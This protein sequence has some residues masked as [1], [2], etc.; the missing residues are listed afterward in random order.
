MRVGILAMLVMFAAGCGGGVTTGAMPAPSPDGPAEDGAPG[1]GTGGAILDPAETGPWAVGVRT[2]EMTDPSRSRT[3]LVDV[4]YPVDPRSPDGSPNEYVLDGPFGPLYQAQ[5]PARRGATPAEGPWPLVLFS[6][7]YGGVRF[8]SHFLTEHLASHGYVVAGPDHPG[9]TLTDFGQLGDDAATAQSA[10]DRP[11]DLR[12]VLDRLVLGI[13]SFEVE[14]DG[15]RVATSGH[16]FGGWTA[17]ETARQDP[18]IDVIVPMA[19]GFKA[20]ATPAFVADLARPLAIVGGGADHTCP[21]D[22]DQQAPYELAQPA[23]A[24]LKVVDAGHLDF[25]NLCDVPLAAIFVS[26]GCDPSSVDP[27]IVRDRSRT[28]AAAFL[29]RYLDVD[30]AYDEY[31]APAYVQSLGN[32]QFW[33]EP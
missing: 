27:A 17:L 11:L 20:G 2:V 14:V 23:K 28:I 29:H 22:T 25:S 8:Q 31:L 21:F 9:N 3:F 16:S 15:D 7:G 12:F 33:R 30:A 5:T 6:H 24:L 4:W 32:V 18:R 1:D 26:D 19:P 13:P 10:V